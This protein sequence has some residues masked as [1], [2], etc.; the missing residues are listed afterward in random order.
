LPTALIID[1]TLESA[2]KACAAALRRLADS[3]LPADLLS[4]IERLSQEKEFLDTDQR[5]E[6]TALADFW[7]KRVIEKL[8]ARAALERLQELAPDLVNGQ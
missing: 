6:L 5:A 7:R 4:R 3:E 8:D 1:P 2:V